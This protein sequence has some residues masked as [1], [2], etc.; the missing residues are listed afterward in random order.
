MFVF[1]LI[2]CQNLNSKSNP[3]VH[4]Y[5]KGVNDLI[6]TDQYYGNIKLYT[7]FLFHLQWPQPF[8]YSLYSQV[9]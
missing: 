9:Q 7:H 6:F 8:I 1:F 2:H 5:M 4:R 3:Y